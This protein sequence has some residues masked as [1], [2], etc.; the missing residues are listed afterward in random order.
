MVGLDDDGG[1][2]EIPVA[3][4]A[5][6]PCAWAHAARA[7][8]NRASAR[9]DAVQRC[10]SATRATRRRASAPFCTAAIAAVCSCAEV[11]ERRVRPGVGQV[12]ARI[13]A[14]RTV[15][16]PQER[17][18]RQCILR[19]RRAMSGRRRGRDRNRDCRGT[20]AAARSYRLMPASRRRHRAVPRL[21]RE[22]AARE[23]SEA[24][25]RRRASLVER[26]RRIRAPTTP[27]Q[28]PE[29]ATAFEGSAATAFASRSRD[30]TASPAGTLEA[31]DI[32][33]NRFGVDGTAARRP[34]DSAG[35]QQRSFRD[36]WRTRL[37]IRETRP[38]RSLRDR[39]R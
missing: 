36:R 21:H 8:V 20:S 14:G 39:C 3:G 23:G 34:A 33:T 4:V 37:P 11:A 32:E 13:V 6:H 17:D 16:L 18:R 19:L 22:P 15:Q 25:S 30:P 7:L 1:R 26:L 2:F 27:P 24:A 28:A 9:G 31:L 12:E 10:A 29:R 35:R 38:R 5:R